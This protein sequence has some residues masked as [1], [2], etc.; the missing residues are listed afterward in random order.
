MN[1]VLKY[2]NC[3]SLEQLIRLYLFSTNFSTFVEFLQIYCNSKSFPK[4]V[5]DI[6]QNILVSQQLL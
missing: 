4:V 6:E 1:S 5:G 3:Y 2:S